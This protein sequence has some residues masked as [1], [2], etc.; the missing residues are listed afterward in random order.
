MFSS[1]KT[2]FKMADMGALIEGQLMQAA[3]VMEEQ[4]DAEINKLEKLDED[5]LEA[6]KQRRINAM[7]KQAEKKRE[8]LSNGHGEYQEI[9]EEK[10]FFEVTKKS[11]NVVCHFYRD[12]TF[13]C[14]I[15]DKHLSEKKRIEKS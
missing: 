15:V 3:A 1:S 14:K 10:D 13:R 11:E 8:W 9:S 7:K 4:L 2:K 5:G 12:E 6:L